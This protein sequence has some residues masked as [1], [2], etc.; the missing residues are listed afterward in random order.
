MDERLDVLENV[1]GATDANGVQAY[2][3]E[4]VVQGPTSP[5][6]AD[7]QALAEVIFAAKAGGVL[8]VRYSVAMRSSRTARAGSTSSGSRARLPCPSSPRGRSA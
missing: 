8:W 6:S 4:A 1:T 7:D 2:S 3:I 5:T